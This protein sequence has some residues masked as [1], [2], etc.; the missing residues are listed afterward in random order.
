MKINEIPLG[1]DNQTFRVMLS[2]INY[3]LKVVWRDE[4]GWILDV[5]DSGAQPLLMGVPLVP[6]VDL[7]EQYPDLGISGALIVMTDN[8]AP[9]YPTKTNLGSSS[10]LYFAQ[11]T[12]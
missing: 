8:G 10:H 1:A 6:D 2:D 5:M 11:V 4:A 9:E 12:A 7:I 3:T